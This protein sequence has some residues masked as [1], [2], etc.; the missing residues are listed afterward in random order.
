M[1]AARWVPKGKVSSVSFADPVVTA[2]CP[3]EECHGPPED[4]GDS[5]ASM[6]TDVQVALHGSAASTHMVNSTVD[7]ANVFTTIHKSLDSVPVCSLGVGMINMSTTL[8]NSAPA[9]HPIECPH[10]NCLDSVLESGPCAV[11]VSAWP[12]NF[13]SGQQTMLSELQLVNDNRAIDFIMPAPD[14]GGLLGGSVTHD[15]VV[16]DNQEAVRN[17]PSLGSENLPTDNTKLIDFIATITKTPKPPLISSPPQSLSLK[18]Q[19]QPTT[20]RSSVRLA[21]KKCIKPGHN[22]D[23]I[24]KAQ[25]IILAKLNNS[26]VKNVDCSSSSNCTNFDESFEQMTS[27][28]IKPL[29]KKQ[30]DAI[31][32]LLN[33]DKVKTAKIK[34][35][36][37]GDAGHRRCRGGGQLSCFVWTG[38]WCFW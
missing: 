6:A 36:E 12:D 33:Q 20:R 27:L 26:A 30:M 34:K 18:S 37:K 5:P 31:M 2:V 4:V 22:R 8:L 15:P 1:P 24:S 17:L 11:P 16:T 38:W 25:E 7:L 9:A 13:L 35:R 10:T 28:L 14:L 3:Q 23:A 19:K 29:S 21:A 32:G